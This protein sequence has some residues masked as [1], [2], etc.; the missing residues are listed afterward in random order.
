[1]KKSQLFGWLFLCGK[2]FDRMCVKTIKLWFISVIMLHCISWNLISIDKQSTWKRCGT[3][4]MQKQRLYGYDNVK[5]IL[6]F[7]VV[8]GHLLEISNPFPGKDVLY[9]LIY[10]CHMPVFIFISGFFAKFHGNKIVFHLIYPYLLF[11]IFLRW[12]FCHLQWLH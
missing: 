10:S 9:K 2:M 5:F 4:N 11:Q 7:L 8:L 6:I 1:M 3:G 12:K